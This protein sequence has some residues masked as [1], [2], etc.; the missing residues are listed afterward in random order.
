MP[1]ILYLNLD[2]SGKKIFARYKNT[3]EEY[4][5]EVG[6]RAIQIKMNF[7]LLNPPEK[8]IEGLKI[9]KEGLQKSIKFKNR[10][11]Q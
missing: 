9:L 5:I 6:D 2:E 11:E 1:M 4:K 3:L 7:L 8:I 10:F